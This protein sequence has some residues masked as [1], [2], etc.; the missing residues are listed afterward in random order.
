MNTKYYRLGLPPALVRSSHFRPRLWHPAP[1]LPEMPL[2]Y[3]AL[4]DK[5]LHANHVFFSGP[6]GRRLHVPLARNRAIWAARRWIKCYRE[7]E[8]SRRVMSAIA[9]CMG[10]IAVL[11]SRS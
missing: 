8:H 5:A 1:K 11:S 7:G 2:S 3:G 4:Y 6:K 10:A 9:D